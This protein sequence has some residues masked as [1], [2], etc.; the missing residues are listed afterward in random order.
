MP[1]SPYWGRKEP[2]PTSQTPS[3]CEQARSQLPRGGSLCEEGSSRCLEHSS[4]TFPVNGEGLDSRTTFPSP[5]TPRG[6]RASR[7]QSRQAYS[8]ARA[9]PKRARGG[10]GGN[11]LLCDLTF[12]CH[13]RLRRT[14]H[15]GGMARECPRRLSARG[16]M[17]LRRAKA[18]SRLHPTIRNTKAGIRH[19]AGCLF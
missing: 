7:N 8:A 18:V 11:R 12:T 1:P 4:A 9:T 5:S 17:T 15:W 13:F 6:C 3:V 14:P 10:A 16:S 2:H 19:S